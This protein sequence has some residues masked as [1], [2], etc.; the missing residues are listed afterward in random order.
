MTPEERSK[1]TS[2]CVKF[3]A[4]IFICLEKLEDALEEYD[5]ECGLG[6]S[7][8]PDKLDDIKNFFKKACRYD[9]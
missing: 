9:E 1:S 4:E 5:E 6:F 3:A 7:D 8:I 2:Y